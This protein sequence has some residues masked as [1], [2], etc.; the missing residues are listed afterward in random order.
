VK[1]AL[2]SDIHGNLDALEAVFENLKDEKIDQW[3]CLGDVVGYGANPEQCVE[4]VREKGCITIAGNHDFA[5]IGKVDTEFFNPYAKKSIEWTTA[6]LSEDAKH[7]LRN[8]PLK[9]V[10]GDF[11][12]S[13]G[14]IHNPQNFGYIS[15]NWDVIMSLQEMSTHI[16]F[17]GHSHVPVTFFESEPLSYTLENIIQ[18]GSLRVIAN[19]GSVGQPRDGNPKASFAIYTNEGEEKS[20]EVRRIDYDIAAAQAKILKAGL[21]EILAERLALGQ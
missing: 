13:H 3:V 4:A 16:G 19:I 8:L 21:P 6:N 9:L 1:Y 14:T 17:L 18:V 10:V 15:T 20:I 12:I 2:I 7:Y 5:A 11:T